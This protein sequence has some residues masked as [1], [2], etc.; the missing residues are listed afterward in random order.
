M[1][2]E[3]RV[4][5]LGVVEDVTIPFAAGMTALTGETGAGKTLLVEAL[6]AVVGGRVSPGAV[7]AG[8]SAAE[9]EARF[10]TTDTADP[11]DHEVILARSV[12]VQGRTRCWVDGRM[13]TLG[14]LSEQGAALV[15][16][17]GQ[18]EHHSLLSPSGQRRALDEFGSLAA[19]AVQQAR[20][21]VRA[22][23]QEM[24]ALGGSPEER[25]RQVDLLGFEV[26]EIQ[27]VGIEDEE[28]DDRL[29]AEEDQLADL[30]AHQD[31][32]HRALALLGGGHGP[33]SIGADGDG[34]LDQVA[35]AAQA[36]AGRDAFG[37]WRGRLEGVASEL[38]DI[39]ADLRAVLERWED[40]PARLEEIQRRR[41]D[42]ADLR[43]K[44]GGHLAA[45]LE[46]VAQAEQRLGE[47]QGLESRL[48]ELA[49]AREQEVAA[50]QGAEATLRR[51]RQEAATAL[52]ASVDRRL[53]TLAM[54]GAALSVA[55]G[56]V[57]AGEEVVFLLAANPG[58]P[59]KPLS[60]VASGGELARTT[61]ALRLLTSGGPDTL[62]FDEVDAGVGGEAAVAL[63]TALGELAIRHQVL[64]V[65]HL[66]QVAAFADHH[67]VVRK[68]VNQ[69]RT[70]T[71]AAVVEGEERIVEISRMLSGH[72][73]SATAR[74]HAAELLAK[75][76][77][78]SASTRAQRSKR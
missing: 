68:V 30:A 58:E 14:A 15:E 6:A 11:Q 56:D 35:A 59:P 51:A 64:V 37:T 62:V 61:L 4:R 19:G 28:E 47:L 66:P 55:V 10:A 43:R 45:V 38:D 44:Y 54:P 49:K 33:A 32:V 3:L 25:A 18:H 46:H 39:G 65:T 42:L 69:G 9:V 17:H 29:R 2:V 78:G 52:G 26:A 1:L 31:A 34:A 72:P 24:A 57:G 70:T 53:H 71:Q 48:G 22:L 60:Q 73:H 74:A 36:L 63:A 16:L 8:A 12:P 20:R 76:A 77:R 5:D 75:G 7:R 50:L 41:R 67:V 27:A 13:A 21:R 40:D 23:D